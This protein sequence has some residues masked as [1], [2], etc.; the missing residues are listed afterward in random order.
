MLHGE[1]PADANNAL[2]GADEDH[3]PVGRDNRE[4]V[5]HLGDEVRQRARLDEQGDFGGVVVAA[6]FGVGTPV[7]LDGRNL[8][9]GLFQP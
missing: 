6:R 5:Q 9:A 2:L 1:A 8:L 4:H 3:S 7:Y